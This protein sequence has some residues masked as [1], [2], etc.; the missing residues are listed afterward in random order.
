MNNFNDIVNGAF[1]I[2]QKEALERQNSELLPIHLLWGFYKNPSSYCSRWLK[3][4]KSLLK[5][6]LEKVPKLG[7]KLSLEELKMSAKLSEWMTYASSY[8]IESNQKEVTEKHFLRFLPKVLSHLD[9]NFDTLNSEHEAE[10]QETPHFLRNLNELAS[11]GK[12]DPVIGRHREIRATMEILGRRSKNNPVL[13]GPAGVG[14]TAIVEGLADAIVKGSVPEVLK[15]KVVYSLDFGSLMAGTKYQGEFEER[16]QGLLKFI[17]SKSGQAILFVDEIHQLVGAGKTTGAM[18]A[19]NLLKPALARG[20]LYCIGATTF[21]EYKKYILDDSALDRRFRPV[22]VNAPSEEDCIEILLGLRDKFEAHHGINISE[23]A[24]FSSVILS[25]QYITDKNLPDKAIDL[26]DEAASSLKL[27]IEGM[28]NELSELEA[29]IRSLKIK[30]QVESDKVEL[31]EQIQELEKKFEKEKELWEQRVLKMKQ[32]SEVKN[33]LDRHRFELEQAERNAD[34]EAASKLKYSVIPELEERLKDSS[35]E[36]ILRKEDIAQV[37]S[38]QTSIPVEKI[39][40]SKQEEILKLEDYLNDRVFGQSEPLHEISETLISS[41]A[42]LKDETRPLGS[43]LLQGPSGVGKTE[44]AKALTQFL[45]NTE[46]NLLRFDLSEFSEKHSVAKLIGAPAGYVGYEE[47]GILTEKVRRN[48]YSVILFDEVEKAHPDFSDILLQI[49]DDGRL[50]DN[51]GYVVDFRNT[52]ILLTT[53]SK[54]IESDFKPEVLGRIDGVLTYSPL[55]ESIMTSL[56]ERELSLLNKRLK[57]RKT[58]I[59]LSDSLKDHIAKVGY[60]PRYGARPLKQKFNSLVIRPLSR[61]IVK[62]NLDKR[63]VVVDYDQVSDKVTFEQH[64]T[65]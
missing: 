56:V 9:L 65:Q 33:Q 15:G 47:G 23:D 30:S 58:T 19:A 49:L 3:D 40:K 8:A 35:Q 54:S 11:Q 62:S 7:K 12:L 1:S 25:N 18:D 60:D 6:E 27:S 28:P 63:E 34:Y 41:Y 52:V 14:K 57:D 2:A 64:V 5:D 48:P 17:K 21:D 50:T 26:I 13:V 20:E 29:E 46:N 32:L 38:R 37:I 10:D 61:E 24:I 51:K 16:L 42:G 4:K 53:N 39:L 45:F 59:R 22:V 36:L 44:T 43:F 31:K 55:N